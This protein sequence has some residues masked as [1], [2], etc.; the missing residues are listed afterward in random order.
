MFEGVCCCLGA[1]VAAWGSVWGHFVVWK[2]I[3]KKKIFFLK[4]FWLSGQ[5]FLLSKCM[6]KSFKKNSENFVHTFYARISKK[7]FV[8]SIHF[9]VWKK[10][11]KKKIFFLKI[12]WLSGQKFLLSKCMK[13]S[14]K[15][16]SENFV[17]TFYCR[18][19]KKIFRNHIHLL[20]GKKFQKK[21]I[22]SE[23]FSRTKCMEKCAL[24]IVIL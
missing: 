12:F 18:I 19:S 23:N 5:K 20:Y 21:N 3:S 17:H 9:V 24:D 2:K 7:I 11:S 8:H 16:N 1:C 14:F 4:I 13:K 15:K 10:I 22:F 6:K